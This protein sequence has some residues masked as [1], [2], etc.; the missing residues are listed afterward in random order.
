MQGN[1]KIKHFTTTLSL[2]LCIWELLIYLPETC[3]SVPC[4]D[5][6]CVIKIF[7]RGTIISIFY[8]EIAK[9]GMFCSYF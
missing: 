4:R 9:E 8:Y 3:L 2:A 1:V 6:K 5:K 7:I